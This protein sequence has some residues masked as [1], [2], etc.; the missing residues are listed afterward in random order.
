MNL[1]PIRWAKRLVGHY[2]IIIDDAAEVARLM[3]K[4]MPQ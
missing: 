3:K 1:L 2:R 4:A